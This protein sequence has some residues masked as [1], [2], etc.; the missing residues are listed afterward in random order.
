VGPAVCEPLHTRPALYE[1]RRFPDGETQVEIHESVRG[2][3]VYLLQSTSPPVD[4]HL[5]ELL[6]LADAC[7]RAGAARL[8]AVILERLSPA[9]VFATDGVTAEPS[10][11]S[12]IEVCSIGP[13]LATAIRRNHHDESLA[14][15][16]ASV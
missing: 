4:Q 15:L 9:H 8:T 3:D 1:C 7:R 12:Q 10:T 13:L 11:A 5:V 2:H 6:L 14:D 16:R